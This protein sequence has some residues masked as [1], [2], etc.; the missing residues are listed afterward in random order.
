MMS[1]RSRNWF[2]PLA[3]ITGLAVASGMTFL[4]LQ[5][6]RRPMEMMYAVLRLAMLLTGA[7]EE[8]CDLE[9]LSMHYYRIGRSGPPLVLIHGLGSSAEIWAPLLPLLSRAYLVYA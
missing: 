5:I 6:Y 1:S 8:T 4:A 3:G 2:T 9:G 7:R